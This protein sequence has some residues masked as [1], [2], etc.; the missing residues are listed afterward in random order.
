MTAFCVLAILSRS[1]GAHQVALNPSFS[2]S[3][4]EWV[5]HSA[6]GKQNQLAIRELLKGTPSLN[7]QP[8]LFQSRGKE[9]PRDLC[10]WSSAMSEVL[11]AP[12]TSI[13]RHGCPWRSCGQRGSSGDTASPLLSLLLRRLPFPLAWQFP[14]FSPES[15]TAQETPQVRENQDSLS[16]YLLISFRSPDFACEPR[17]LPFLSQL[18]ESPN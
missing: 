17:N 1:S 3:E 13:S 8:D 4:I 9:A 6:Q 18:T 5:R 15:S 16:P 10:E 12:E 7:P 11:G 14:G 2:I